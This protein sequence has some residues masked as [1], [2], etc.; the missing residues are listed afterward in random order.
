M[1]VLS[2]TI[3]VTVFLFWILGVHT[4][5]HRIVMAMAASIVIFIGSGIAIPAVTSVLIGGGPACD[6][7]GELLKDKDGNQVFTM[8]FVRSYSSTQG[9]MDSVL[10]LSASI[11]GAGSL[12]LIY[13]FLRSGSIAYSNFNAADKHNKNK[14][15]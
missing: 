2:I 10:Y 9:S 14:D 11:I 3:T 13:R 4:D 15:A 7:T 8:K 5:T 1:A 12:L 6:A